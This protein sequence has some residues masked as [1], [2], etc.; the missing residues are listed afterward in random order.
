V[1]DA[2]QKAPELIDDVLDKLRCISKRFQ[3][4][5]T[6]RNLRLAE[7][8]LNRETYLLVEFVVRCSDEQF[9]ACFERALPILGSKEHSCGLH[10]SAACD[11][12]RGSNRDGNVFKCAA[13]GEQ[14]AMLVDNVEFMEHP[15]G[16]PVPSLVRLNS[17]ERFYR[18]I[19]QSLYFSRLSGVVFRGGVKNRECDILLAPVSPPINPELHCGV[20]QGASQVEDRIASDYGD[21]SWDSPERL[22]VID[23]TSRLRITLGSDCAWVGRFEG[24]E[25]GIEISDVLFGPFEFQSGT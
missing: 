20:I 11:A 3:D 6:L 4:R 19:P 21:F 9:V 16:V 13:N 10:P 25:C 14:Q 7:R 1:T 12:S 23:W 5:I 18:S 15:K 8:Y 24:P 22:H 17:I 2:S